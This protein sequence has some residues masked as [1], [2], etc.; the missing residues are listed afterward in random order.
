MNLKQLI[1][2][3]VQEKPDKTAIV[4]GGLAVT[5]DQL[6]IIIQEIAADLKPL[7]IRKGSLVGI[8]FPNSIAYVAITFALWELDA[9]VVPI[10]M[11]LKTSEVENICDTMN[12]NAVIHDRESLSGAAGAVSGFPI[13]YFVDHRS[14]A[15]E[16]RY[17]EKDIAFIRFTSGTTGGSK[18]VVLSHRAIHE[19]IEAVNQT[20]CIGPEDTILWLLSMAHHFVSTI[21]LYLANN[22]TIVVVNKLFAGS[23]LDAVHQSQATVLY[24]SPFHYSLLAAD[25]SDKMLPTVRLALSTTIELPDTVFNDFYRRYRLPISQAYGIIEIGIVCMNT[26]ASSRKIGS[27]GRILPA[28]EMKVQNTDCYPGESPLCGELWFRGPGFFDAYFSPW[29]DADTIMKEGWFDTGDIGRIDADGYV[30]LFARK[31]DVINIA[32]MKVFPQEIEAVLNMHPDIEESYVYGWKNERFGELVAADIVPK[33][34]PSDVSINDILQHCRQRLA[35]YK[36]PEDLKF[37]KAIRK[38]AVTS[39]IIRRNNWPKE[40]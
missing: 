8:R 14:P 32:G 17:R 23:I 16:N 22:A 33:G 36:V 38:T 18:G 39:K 7:G 25:T 2:K 35:S 19:R 1:R 12:L 3:S 40:E 11:E 34:S 5:Y 28:Y 13:H 21:I 26:E 4:E 24:A 10:G 29:A 37:V 20:L 6:F 30:Y 31:K 15:M 27:V 9:I